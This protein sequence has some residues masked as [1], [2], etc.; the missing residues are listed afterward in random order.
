[1]SY[2][3][4]NKCI[5]CKQQQPCRDAAVL[6]GAITIIHNLGDAHRGSGTV[7]LDCGRFEAKDQPKDGN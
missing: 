3:L 5:E 6:Q 1:M 4:K 7:D 2:Y